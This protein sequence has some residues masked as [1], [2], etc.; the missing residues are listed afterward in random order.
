MWDMGP[1][2]NAPG[3]LYEG[4]RKIPLAIRQTRAR[5]QKFLGYV[6]ILP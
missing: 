2:V 6:P 5:F 4:R 3:P 1:G